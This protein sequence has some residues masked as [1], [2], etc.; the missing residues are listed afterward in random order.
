MY[1]ECKSAADGSI[2]IS[3]SEDGTTEVVEYKNRKIRF[4]DISTLNLSAGLR[5]AF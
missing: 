3:A 4:D 1:Q 2:E 5:I